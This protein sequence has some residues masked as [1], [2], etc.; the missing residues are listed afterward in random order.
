MVD[1]R[2]R[3]PRLRRRRSFG[4]WSEAEFV[5]LML[6][7]RARLAAQRRSGAPAGVD[8]HLGGEAAEPRKL[9]KHELPHE[10]LVDPGRVP[11][12]LSWRGT[13]ADGIGPKDQ[14]TCGE[15]VPRNQ[16]QRR[17][18][19][20]FPWPAPLP[21]NPPVVSEHAA[22]PGLAALLAAPMPQ[23]P[24]PGCPLL[25]EA[26]GSV[27][28]GLGFR[29]DQHGRSMWLAVQDGMHAAC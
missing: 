17:L 14:A 3:H 22:C 5:A 11:A 15:A 10:P 12:Q 6:P 19:R 7:R 13:G 18:A 2:W 16:R 4:D 21:P 24:L 20:L 9:R 23:V 1:V 26:A 27:D 28:L 8:D 25:Q 29:V